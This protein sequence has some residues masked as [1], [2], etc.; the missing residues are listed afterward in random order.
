MGAAARVTTAEVTSAIARGSMVAGMW[1]V[2]RSRPATRKAPSKANSAAGFQ[3]SRLGL[4]TSRTPRKPT[5]TATQRRGPTFSFSTKATRPVITIGEANMSV[6]AL[7][8]GSA[9]RAE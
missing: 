8:T 4:A 2:I 6:V 3:P 7:A 5:I 1:R 9:V